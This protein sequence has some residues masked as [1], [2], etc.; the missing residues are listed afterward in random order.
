MRYIL[1]ILTIFVIKA[2]SQEKETLT[3]VFMG[4]VMGHDSQ[5]N[6]ARIGSSNKY[7]YN[8]CFRYIKDD[9]KSADLAI[10]NLEVTL[11]GEPYKGYPTFSSPDTIADA[12][13]H[14]GIDAL[15]MAN[16]HCVDRKKYGLERTC[17]VLD[18][19]GIPR[20]GVFK[21]SLDKVKNNPLILEAKGFKIAVLNYTYGTNGI[22]V[23]SPNIVNQLDTTNMA[24]DITLAKRRG[25]DEIVVC[26]HWGWEYQTKPNPEQK[27]LT[28]FLQSKGVNIIIGSH[29]HVLQPM[30]VSSDNKNPQLVAY[31][32]GNFISN[33]RPKPRDGAALL[34][35]KITK[36]KGVTKVT[37]AEYQLT[38]V[39]TPVKAG[40][41]HF[42]VLPA[43]RHKD[44]DW[45]E[46]KARN[47]MKEY[48]SEARDILKYNLG[49]KERIFTI[50]NQEL[51]GMQMPAFS[52]KTPS[53]IQTN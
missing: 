9:I 18:L 49:V 46:E 25:V 42:Y 26:T 43:Q 32:M 34:F 40:K 41:K 7:D 22:R 47:R 30:K 24:D 3:M 35:V 11:A 5:I 4:D 31:S 37:N 29:P 27:K 39:Y 14:A 6:S 8:S 21:D 13:K 23:Q 50:S 16:N 2:Q 51:Q 10:A 36:E 19:K 12:L 48:L 53:K 38:W 33:Q 17:D 44:D 28:A 45:I 1:L 52:I 20:T 15:V